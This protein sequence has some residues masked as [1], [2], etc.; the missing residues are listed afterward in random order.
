LKSLIRFFLLLGV[1]ILS[2]GCAGVVRPE[3]IDHQDYVPIQEN[4]II[5]QTFLSRFDALN[6][7]QIYLQPEPG[8]HGK[9]HFYLYDSPDLEK[10]VAFNSINIP[11]FEKPNPTIIQFHPIKSSQDERFYVF[12]EWEGEGQLLVESSSVDS[13]INGSG[14]LDHQPGNFQLR[15]DLSYD[16]EMLLMG[17]I[18][19]ILEWAY[20]LLVAGALFIIPGWGLLGLLWPGWSKYS[21]AVRFAL[22]AGLSL[23]IYPILF[24]WTDVFGIHLGALYAWL[25][26]LLGAATI[27]WNFRENFQP[28]KFTK[29]TKGLTFSWAD[30]TMVLVMLLTFSIRFWIIRNISIP[31]WG[32]SYQHSVIAQLLVNH[33]GLFSNWQPYAELSTLTYH[34]GFHSFAAVFHWVTKLPVPQSTLITGQILNG[35]AVIALVPLT[36]KVGSN[37]WSGLSA[38]IISGLLIPMPNYYVNWGRYTQLAGLVILPAAV[39]LLWELF[40]RKEIQWKWLVIIWIIL[41]GLALTHYRVILF[42]PTFIVAYLIINSR[43][44]FTFK[45]LLLVLLAGT[46]ALIIFL[47]WLVRLLDSSILYHFINQLITFT[48]QVPQLRFER[49]QIGDIFGYLPVLLWIILPLVIAWGL[50][51]RV[52]NAAVISLWWFLLFLFTN[53]HWFNLP[54]I[55]IITNFA[56]FISLYLPASVLTDGA[57]SWTIAGFQTRWDRLKQNQTGFASLPEWLISICILVLVFVISLWGMN[58][59]RFDIDFLSHTLVTSPDLE[60][61]KWIKKSIPPDA[62]FLVNSTPAFGDIAIVGTDAGWW[63]PL[64]TDRKTTLPPLNYISEESSIPGYRKNIT[65]L[66]SEINSKGF[67]DPDVIKLLRENRITHIFLGQRGG[68]VNTTI[69]PIS[70]STLLDHPLFDLLYNKDQVW[71]FEFIG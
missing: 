54:G 14:Y 40:D 25:P 13:Y 12:I 27:C 15:F 57:I 68:K 62:N 71:I 26:V 48:N 60:A 38:I 35:L 46:G 41:S 31:L 42:L 30:I 37:K 22:S 44:A 4:Q 10:Q 45:F 8:A 56:F 36:L 3:Q 43:D 21:W 9:I 29:L 58:Q 20:W 51:R 50:W 1:T 59:R 11:E 69:S 49:N 7:F 66:S 52:K 67:D 39:Y 47:P 16:T 33:R 28:G 24:L 53:P 6:G 17:M 2:A 70:T 5:G 19:G 65:A 61:M 23:A 64:L 18:K 32:D 63:I 34:F 55:G